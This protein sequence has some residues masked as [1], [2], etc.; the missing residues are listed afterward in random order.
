MKQK[1]NKGLNRREFL[2]LSALGLTGLTILPSYVVNGVRM[3]PSDRV[4]MGFIGAADSRHYLILQ[5]LQV[6]PDVQV[7]A[8]CD[9]DSMKQ[10]PF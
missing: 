9:V 6:L 5:D 8:C 7:V 3:A 4:V 1:S 2:G 10:H